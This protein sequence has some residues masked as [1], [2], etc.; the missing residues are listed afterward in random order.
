[1][2]HDRYYVDSPLHPKETISIEGSEFRHM[3]VMRAKK[4]DTIELVNGKG[5][6]AHASILDLQKK[7]AS[8]HIESVQEKIQLKK[9]I[10]AQGVCRLNKL[11]LI[12]EKATELGVTHFWLFAAE[13]S[14]KK[15][16][17]S[18]QLERLQHI[19]ISAMKQCGRLDLPEIVFYKSLDLMPSFSGSCFFGDVREN[20]PSLLQFLPLKKEALFCVG[21]EKGF[22]THEVSILEKRNYQPVHLSNNILRTETAALVGISLLSQS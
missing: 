11:D 7:Q 12:L 10:L 5:Q 19:T 20:P 2:P 6:L 15:Q 9:L 13:R 21:P 8:V 14:E 17:S 3:H 4:G 16:M 22:S 18:H 1:M